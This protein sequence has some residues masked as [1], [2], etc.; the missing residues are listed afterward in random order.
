MTAAISDYNGHFS[1]QA[2]AQDTLVVS[3]LGF[4]TVYVPVNS[5][6]KID[7]VLHYDTTTLQEVRIN[8]GYYTVKESERTGS[9]ARITSKDI[10][11]QPV[12]NVLATMQGRM[13]GVNIIQTTGV[14]GGGFDIKIRGQNSLRTTA[15]NPLYIIDG[16]PFASDPIGYSQ[17]STIYPSSTS[18]LNS[19]NPETI[20]SIEVLKDAD[21]TSIYGSRGANGV[22]LIT[23]KKGKS[24]R[25]K[26]T[27]SSSTGAGKATKFMKLMDT[28]QY[29]AMRKQAFIN[30]GIPQYGTSD[31]D[32]NG[33]W[34]QNRN[35]D[36]QR[37]LMGGTS[38]LNDL[39]GSVSGGSEK[40][41]FLIGG[42]YHQES[43][44]YSGDFKYKKGG[45]Q[46]SL[47]H[48]SKDDRFHINFSG[49][50][51]IQNSSLPANELT[52]AA[53]TLAPNAP[54][55]YNSDGSLNWENQTWQNPLAMLNAQF[56]AKTKDLVANA[57][58]S[59]KLMPELTVKSNFG[60]TDLRTNETR[61]TP[62]TIYDPIYNISS[63]RSSMFSNITGRSSWIVEPQLNWDK[64]ANFGKLGLLIGATFQNQNSS[65]L[66]QSGTGFSSNSLI[67]N[68][69]AAKT[70]SVLGDDETV[71][72]Y[73]A[74]FAR[75]NY[76]YQQR[77]IINLTA[78][79]DGSS[80][81][82]PGRQFASFGAAGFAWLFSNE[83]FLK[84]STWLSF[85]KIRGSYGTTGNDQ[86]G[87][88]QYLN[89]Y[90]TTGI[91]YNGTVGM[92][93]SR[94]FNPDFSWEI[95]KKMELALETGFFNDRIFTTV[96]WYSNRSSNQL[97]GIPLSGVTG[98]ASIQANLNAEV[99]NSGLELTLRSL[100]LKI[101]NVQWQTNFNLSFAK[102]RLVS[103]P[104]LESSTYSQR[105][106]IG[107]PLN[108][109][110]VYQLKGVNQQ[111]GIYEFE[112]LNGD[113]KISYPLDRQK[114]VNLNPKYYGGLQ[115]QLSYKNW[116]LDF[117]FQF[118][119]QQNRLVPMGAAGSM[120]NQPARTADAWLQAGDIKPYQVYTT[121]VN[122]V[123]VNAD[124][125]FSESDALISD[126]SFI[127]LKNISLTY[128]LPLKFTETS[129][130]IVFQ[131][132]NLLTFTKFKDGDP[133]FSSYGFL[134]PLKVITAGIL[135][136]F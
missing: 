101:K 75:L 122:N 133:E 43:T 135:L 65:A 22:V 102:N 104:G 132:Q 118:A 112:D 9:I 79:R 105:Y 82:G 58:L 42:N 39:Q 2:S 83:K 68:L 50:Y 97:V 4:K 63:S 87:D 107:Q 115:N 19:I 85:G 41:Q 34:N 49:V 125:Y 84:N 38:Q 29:L 130:K 51:N 103:F 70:V 117:L 6:T 32:I 44:V 28:E 15:N 37:E 136:T 116:N 10:E 18:P 96:S 24:G 54:S 110:L 73:Q 77:Y 109:A 78:R 21:A 16:V 31:Y 35:T 128:Q 48:A 27:V 25:T 45:L 124:S 1:I 72:R 55:L 131:G 123:A 59:Y 126:S 90:T 20:E 93:P 40:T 129:C 11:T 69:A 114:T 8:A 134:P 121:G 26:F 13:A 62:S 108:I 36:W 30:D 47:N 89:T 52:Y 3:Y 46:F 17:T 113:G 53:Q 106:R 92:Q 7:I 12:T 99:E 64:E 86:I 60:Y 61:T 91:N 80:R 56:K 120:S 5:R 57:V 23:T 88:Y 98:F 81:F 66:Y 71:Y 76:S 95:N 33:T 94:L 100:N 14:P 74:F 127:R 111:T 119:K 67:Y